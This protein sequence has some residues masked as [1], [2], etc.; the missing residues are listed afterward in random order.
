MQKTE[1]QGLKK[2]PR[3]LYIQ[4]TIKKKSAIM[5]ATPKPLGHNKEAKSPGSVAHAYNPSYS[6]G[7][8]QEDHSLMSA[9]G[10]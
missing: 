4:I 9:P 7:R 3:T 10:K 6:G 1:Y 2:R 8:D 5:T